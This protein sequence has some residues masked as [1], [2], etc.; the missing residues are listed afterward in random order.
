M[1]GARRD[2]AGTR[3]RL[4]RYLWQA[5]APAVM[6]QPVTA[7]GSLLFSNARMLAVAAITWAVGLADTRCCDTAA[8]LSS[9]ALTTVKASR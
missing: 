1:G 5:T 3:T 2:A 8:R 4:V 6:I 7:L 9:P